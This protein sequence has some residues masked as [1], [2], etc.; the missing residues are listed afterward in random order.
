MRYLIF[1]S[2]ISEPEQACCYLDTFAE[3]AGLNRGRGKLK[4][5]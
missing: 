2:F 3:G 5:G 1:S 4:T